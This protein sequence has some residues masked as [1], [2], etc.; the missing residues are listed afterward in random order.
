MALDIDTDF[1]KNNLT[2][3]NTNHFVKINMQDVI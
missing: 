2:M 3:L 1:K